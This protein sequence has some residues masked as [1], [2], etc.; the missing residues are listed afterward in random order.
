MAVAVLFMVF[1]AIICYGSWELGAGWASDGPQAGYFPFYLGVIIILTSVA[2][3]IAAMRDKKAAARSYVSAHALGQVM[4]VLVPAAIYAGAVGIIG[5]YV[6][7]IIYITVFMMWI[8]KYSF[9]KSALI[10]LGVNISFFLLFEIWFHV[11]L[12]KGPVEALLGLD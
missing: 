2:I 12:P 11:P 5:I 4:K 7:S 10:G 3:F 6:S 9:I 1:G 8:G